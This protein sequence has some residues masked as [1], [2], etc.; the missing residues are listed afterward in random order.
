MRMK[1]TNK[2]SIKTNFPETFLMMSMGTCARKKHAVDDI[3][4]QSIIKRNNVET[5]NLTHT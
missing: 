4:F 5:F 1:P 3:F 2:N